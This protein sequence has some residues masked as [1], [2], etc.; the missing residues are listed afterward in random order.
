MLKARILAGRIG[1]PI[2]AS[3]A[4]IVWEEFDDVL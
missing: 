4:G 1:R 3:R 2:A